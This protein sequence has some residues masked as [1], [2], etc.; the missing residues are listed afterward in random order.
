[1]PF[2]MHSH[3]GQFCPGHA[4]DSLEEVVQRAIAL[5]MRILAMTEH[6][7]REQDKDLYPEEVCF[8][9]HR[10]HMT[11]NTL[12]IEHQTSQLIPNRIYCTNKFPQVQVGD[13]P[14]ILATRHEAY[15]KE[16]TRLQ[17]K[18]R[19]QI[20]ILTGFE[21]EWIRPS[22][23]PLIHSLASSPLVDFFI[24]SI[25]HVHEIPIDFD[26]SMYL[27]ARKISGGTDEGLFEDYFD[28]QYE[29]IKAVRPRIIGHFDLI[30][31]LSDEPDVD[32]MSMPGVWERVRRNLQLIREQ[33][34]LVEIN[35]SAL[36]KGMR[37]PYPGRSVC[38]EFLSMGGRFTLSD[39][40]HGVAQVG[41]NF[42]RAIEY[43]QSLGIT[44]LH[45][46]EKQHGNSQTCGG[47]SLQWKA[48]AL[49]DLKLD[50]FPST[51][52]K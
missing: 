41:L 51:I 31:L 19:P 2:T 27:T 4:K 43:V 22:Y 42:K 32:L 10:H 7:P 1:M 12:P 15:L 16:A 28:G 26:R 21:S 46:L 17:S 44:E 39:D 50:Q 5:K 11:P 34:G 6:M 48:L 35:S 52:R 14:A 3:S 23:G 25:H 24:G 47:S 20:T 30:R 37:E 8:P 13:T 38:E 36:R 45:Y 29:M 9:P 33:G 49:G 18:Y 40:S